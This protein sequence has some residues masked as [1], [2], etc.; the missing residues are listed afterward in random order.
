MSSIS[1]SNSNNLLSK[2]GAVLL[3]I[4]VQEKLFPHMEEKEKIVENLQRLIKFAKIMEIPIIL[5][6]QYSKGLGKTIPEI[7]RLIPH[8]RPIH[9]VEF[10]CF[11]SEEFKRLMKEMEAKTLILT[12]IETHICITQTALEGLSSYRIC[13]ISDA[14]SSRTIENK[15]IALE[16]MRQNGVIISST[17]MLIYEI[18]RKAGTEEFKKC[19]TLVK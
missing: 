12:G 2:E 14:V 6:E 10:S 7:K 4:D 9:K 1:K 18:L 11:G 8:I 16:R 15:Q 5:T 17:E 3:I 19:L 13:V